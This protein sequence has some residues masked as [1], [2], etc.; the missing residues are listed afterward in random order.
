LAPPYAPRAPHVGYPPYG[1]P[2]RRSGR[3]V[4]WIVG[5]IVAV[6]LI[7]AVACAASV[8]VLLHTISTIATEPQ[9]TTQVSRTFAVG[10]APTVVAH[11]IVGNLTVSAGRDGT[12]GVQVTKKARDVSTAAARRDLEV[13][14][15]TFAQN[16][17][18]VSV[19][20]SYGNGVGMTRQLWADLAITVPA[21]TAVDLRVTTG[22][23]N[24]TGIRGAIA[25]T[26]VTGNVTA[27]GVTIG[28][29]SHINLTTG[30]VH[31]DAA[32]T[33]DGSLDVGVVT[34]AI[35]VALPA[36]TPA[37]L[38][39]STVTG[40]IAIHGWSIPVTGQFASHKASGDLAPHP[41]A[42]L[43]LHLTTGSISLT[44]R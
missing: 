32:L 13:I 12:I 2:P 42:T 24:L 1:T 17:D 25:A 27:T 5:G 15:I 39:A 22:N 9:A 36:A 23:L 38:D 7:L 44:A 26:I 8:G 16:G 21:A 43:R 41:T 30:N 28:R 19:D 33:P 37:H 31:A 40:N 14:T 20:A 4:A 18:R 35:D 29:G 10:G 6:A 3:T 11:N 34:G